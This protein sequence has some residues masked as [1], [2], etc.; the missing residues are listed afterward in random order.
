MEESIEN[1]APFNKDIMENAEL[2]INGK[3]D[4]LGCTRTSVHALK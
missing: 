4:A 3:C 1:N 2:A